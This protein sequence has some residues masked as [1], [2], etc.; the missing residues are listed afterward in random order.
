MILMQTPTQTPTPVAPF[1]PKPGAT[2]TVVGGDGKP[3]TL[4]IPRTREEIRAIQLQREQISDQLENVSSRRSDVAEELARTASDAAK[5]GLQQRLQ[6]LDQRI[7]QLESELAS[8]GQQLAAAPAELVAGTEL[9][10]RPQPDDNF[11]SGVAVGG[12]SAV[13]VMAVILIV[14]GRRWRRRAPKQSRQLDADATQR[15]QRLEQGMDAI[16]IEI[17]RVSEGQ[18][19]VTRLLSESHAAEQSAGRAGQPAVIDRAEPGKR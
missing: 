5:P 4:P 17:E 18:R 1:T 2:Y 14:L 16:A 7:I 12:T 19:F 10:D 3:Q 15:L 8:T 6:V 13:A 11:S 9:P